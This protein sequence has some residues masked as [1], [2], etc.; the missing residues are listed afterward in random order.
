MLLNKILKTYSILLS[1]DQVKNAFLVRIKKKRRK[2][3]ILLFKMVAI[4]NFYQNQTL[5]TPQT[6]FPHSDH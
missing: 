2:R 1:V 4:Y 6:S 5:F 3:D